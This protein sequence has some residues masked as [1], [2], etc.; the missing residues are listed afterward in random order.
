MTANAFDEAR[1]D[2]Y[3]AGMD[4]HIAKPIDVQKLMGTLSRRLKAGLGREGRIVLVIPG[5]HAIIGVSEHQKHRPAQWA[6]RGHSHDI[7]D[8]GV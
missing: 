2:A 8:H 5:G 4:A 7:F 1:A 6:E 3:A